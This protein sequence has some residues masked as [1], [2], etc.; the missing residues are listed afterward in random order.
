MT[1]HWYV[2]LV[3]GALFRL[4]QVKRK[5]EH[6]LFVTVFYSLYIYILLSLSL[7]LF[8]GGSL[9]LIGV[10]AFKGVK[11]KKRGGGGGFLT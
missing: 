4:A 1:L 11:R 2:F 7:S 5:E 6:A 10:D 3:E 8:F 9:K